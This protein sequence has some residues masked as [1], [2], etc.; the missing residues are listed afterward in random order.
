MG[1]AVVCISLTTAAGGEPIGHAV[2]ERLGF[3]YVDDEV[4]PLAAETAGLEP[5]V[6]EEAEHQPGLLARL[7]D[8]LVAPPR[9]PRGFLG[10]RGPDGYYAENEPP[11]MTPPREEL[12]RLIRSAILEIARR[13][14]V[15]IVAHAASVALAEHPGVLRVL[16][17]ASVDVRVNRLWVPNKL[18]SEEEYAKAVAESDRAR[19][20]YLARFYDVHEEEPTLYDLV[21]NTDRLDMEQAVAA[22]ASAATT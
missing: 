16:V 14:R 17:T 19:Q 22:I 6:L 11:P 8:A 10:R 5:A 13:G 7:M 21:V 9:T 3:R 1:Y 2:A 4:I 18:V 15:V 12:R 20:R